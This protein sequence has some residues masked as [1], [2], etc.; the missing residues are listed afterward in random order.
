MRVNSAFLRYD[1]RNEGCSMTI[2]SESGKTKQI[3]RA[4]MNGTP[5]SLLHIYNGIICHCTYFHSTF[6]IHHW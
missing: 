5:Y 3:R 4:N 2:G 1:G 6:R